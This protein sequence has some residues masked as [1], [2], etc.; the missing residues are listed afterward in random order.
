MSLFIGGLAFEHTGGDAVTYL[1]THRLG[2][3]SGSLISGLLGYFILKTTKQVVPE[4]LGQEEP[5]ATE[6]AGPGSFVH[7]FESTDDEK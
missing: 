2:I 7:K 5:V 4:N 3:L 1:T 6:P